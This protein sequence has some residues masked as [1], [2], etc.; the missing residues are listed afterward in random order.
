[1]KTN[2]KPVTIKDIAT[3]AK[4]SIGT[5]DRVLHKRGRVAADVEKRVLRI[6]KETDY[7]PNIIARTLVSKN[8]YQI[9]ALLPNGSFGNYWFD[10]NL[11]IE[12]AAKE[13]KRYGL[14]INYYHFNPNDPESFTFQATELNKKKYNTII[15]A[16]IFHKEVIPFLDLWKAQDVPYIFF[17]NEIPDCKPLSYIGQDNYQSGYLAG[18]LVH[19]GLAMPCSILIIHFNQKTTNANHLV[20][21]EKGFKNYFTENNLQQFKLLTL[22]ITNDHKPSFIQQM[23]HTFQTNS[24]IKAVFVTNAKVYNVAEYLTQKYLS[25]IKVVGYDLLPKNLHYLKQNSISFLINQ[26][27]KG[28]AFA[29]LQLLADKLIFNKP[30]PQLKYLPLDIVTKENANYFIHDEVPVI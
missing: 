18:K 5:V 8:E 21:K 28:Q 25:D 16:P 11:G 22:D 26:N 10:A 30:V 23:D 27:P 2:D 4:V 12:T 20:I 14:T 6:I 29:A 15:L 17:N 3:K 13:L 1:M 24:N 9:A 19:Y 7:Q